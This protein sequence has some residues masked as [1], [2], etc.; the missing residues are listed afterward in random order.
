MVLSQVTAAGATF[1]DLAAAMISGNLTNNELASILTGA[2]VVESPARTIIYGNRVL[3]AGSSASLSYSPST[4]LAFYWRASAT[5]TQFL[6][7]A[8][9]SE[10]AQY[11]GLIPRTNSGTASAGFSYKVTPRTEFSMDAS[12]SRTFSTYQDAYMT[13]GR[14]RLG[15]KIGN[16]WFVAGNGG[17]GKII[18]IRETSELPRGLQGVGGGNVGFRTRG[19]TFVASVDRTVADSYGLGAGSTVSSTGSWDWHRPG[20]AWRFAASGG[21]QRLDGVIE[22]EGWAVKGSIARRITRQ[23]GWSLSYAYMSNAQRA[24]VRLPEQAQMT[25]H[26]VRL[27]LF[28]SPEDRR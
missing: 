17:V 13:M 2:P 6:Q 9:N 11:R 20:G 15:R 25:V 23:T 27:A 10:T 21:W 1:D 3:S 12:A 7:D 22:L 24:G 18:P 26:S 8:A 19:N 28:W 16:R 4:R 5:R 14:L